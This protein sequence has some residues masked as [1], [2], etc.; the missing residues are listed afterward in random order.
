[1]MII[2]SI[3][4][5]KIAFVFMI[6]LFA[7]SQ[8]KRA[9]EISMTAASDIPPAMDSPPIIPEE[10]KQLKLRPGIDRVSV[11]TTVM[12]V[13]PTK[14][15]V[16]VANGPK[17]VPA[18]TTTNET[19]TIRSD[20]SMMIVTQP[21]RP[22]VVRR[23]LNPPPTNS[24]MN[25]CL[26]IMDDT[27]RL[28]EWLA[29]H[30]TVLPLGHLVVA[31]DSNSKR[32]HEI[33]KILDA[34]REYITIDAHYNDTFLTLGPHEGW[35]RQIFGGPNGNRTR[36][37]FKNKKGITYRSQAHKR[38]QN[39]FA[40]FCFRELYDK[41]KRGWT[42]L[43]DT[44]EFVTFNYRYP[45]TEDPSKYDSV[46][47]FKSHADVDGDRA[48]VIPYRDLLAN[49][50]K[51]VTIA[52]YLDTYDEVTQARKDHSCMRIPGLT[53]T[54][55]A[56]HPSEMV[57]DF[58]IG[59][60]GSNLMTLRQRQHAAKDGSFSKAMLHLRVAPNK[61]WFR[62]G[63]VLNVHTPNRQ[64]C[65]RTTKEDHTG[66]G[67]DY[68]SSLFRLHHYKAGTVEAYLERA[69]DWRGGGLWRFYFDR[70]ADAVGENSDLTQW[71]RWFV[72]K[73]GREA[74]DRL[75]LQ[76]LNDTYNR[77]GSLR[78]VAEAKEKI[79]KI[80]PNL[81]GSNDSFVEPKPTY[82]NRANHTIGACMYIFDGK[83]ASH[84]TSLVMSLFAHPTSPVPSYSK[85]DGM[86]SI[87][88][89]G[90]STFPSHP[91]TRPQVAK[92]GKHRQD[93]PY[94]GEICQD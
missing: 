85:P 92:R 90:A 61:G 65:G 7:G 87:S 21:L 64:M 34:W 35:G 59:M 68:V 75:L 39:F 31:I 82:Y 4:V 6:S 49:M 57:R 15:L 3:Q 54:S 70:S 24:T 53:F 16:A 86:A 60:D 94:M 63:T 26:F 20:T 18:T 23:L 37:W 48:R 2:D 81:F 42:L 25:A 79:A 80:V 45:A 8:I 33:N 83:F 93:N 71:F 66:S 78:H 52:Q 19:S 91:W 29:Y 77:I 30:Y 89:H 12:A 50:T 22:A 1:M 84:T 27:I 9:L 41:R 10:L 76:P 56:I 40:G 38:R 74:A 73:V 32:I 44:D 55:H 69:G 46:T 17:L 88:L 58:P 72:D 11:N 51:R 28:L 14:S 62:D 43:T 5:R 13:P 47:Q 36:G 67:A